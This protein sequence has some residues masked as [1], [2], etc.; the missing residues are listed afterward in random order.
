RGISPR[1]V[2]TTTDVRQ[3]IAAREGTLPA[4][5]TPRLLTGWRAKFLDD[6][7]GDCLDGRFAMRFSNDLES[8]PLQL[9]DRQASRR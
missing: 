5:E 6:F 1:L 9:I 4:S 7:I 2:S 8:L 3:V